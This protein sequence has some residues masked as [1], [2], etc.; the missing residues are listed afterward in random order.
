MLGDAIAC[1]YSVEA[2]ADT[3]ASADRDTDASE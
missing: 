1:P 2:D 3:A